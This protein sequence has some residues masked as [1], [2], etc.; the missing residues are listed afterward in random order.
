MYNFK[1]CVTSNQH[2]IDLKILEIVTLRSFHDYEELEIKYKYL[3]L[4]LV[5]S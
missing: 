5:N 2:Y 1:Y 4:D 3:N